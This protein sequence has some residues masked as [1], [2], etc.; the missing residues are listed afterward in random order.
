MGEICEIT[1]I[2]VIKF[3]IIIFI[4]SKHIVMHC[5]EHI[6][7]QIWIY[8][9]VYL[10]RPDYRLLTLPHLPHL[11][12]LP[13]YTYSLPLLHL[14]PLPTYHYRNGQC[15]EWL[16]FLTNVLSMLWSPPTSNSLCSVDQNTLIPTS[17][18][19]LTPS[20]S[21]GR[22]LLLSC[23]QRLLSIVNTRKC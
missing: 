23:Y 15:R 5:N 13:F 3:N 6:Y 21:E 12:I 20:S 4:N 18:N 19:T 10:S 14:T 8:S 9:F 22:S 16:R 11:Y 1:I 17:D 2:L 7:S